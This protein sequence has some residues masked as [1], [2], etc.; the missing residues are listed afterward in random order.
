LG[1]IEWR[2]YEEERRKKEY[3]EEGILLYNGLESQLGGKEKPDSYEMWL[4]LKGLFLHVKTKSYEVLDRFPLYDTHDNVHGYEYAYVWRGEAIETVDPPESL[5]NRG[6][7]LE[8]TSRVTYAIS[9]ILSTLKKVDESQ[10]E[11]FLDVLSNLSW[12]ESYFYTKFLKRGIFPG[13]INWGK[14]IQ[15]VISKLYKHLSPKT[16]SGL[17]PEA[18]ARLL[19]ICAHT[20]LDL[21]GHLEELGKDAVEILVQGLRDRNPEIRKTAVAWLGDAGDKKALEPLIEVLK[22][23]NTSVSFAAVNALEKIG[24]ERAIEPLRCYFER[25]HSYQR[26]HVAD[27]I[28]AI[29]RTA[30]EPYVVMLEEAE[31]ERGYA[32][33]VLEKARKAITE[34]EKIGNERALDFLIHHFLN[35]EHSS[36]ATG[37]IARYLGRVGNEKAIEALIHLYKREKERGR[38]KWGDGK[39]VGEVLDQLGKRPK[40]LLEKLLRR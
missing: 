29:D 18:F 31:N 5:L 28:G 8:V 38:E 39:V 4:L 20:S 34:L 37:D 13:D 6:E 17:D 2:K 14:S 23:E 21:I 9:Q 27:A 22:D 30:I 35:E 1:R 16:I 24:D 10:Q 36:I 32:L 3:G 7:V 11:L 19:E 33:D 15:P 40:S 26:K 25:C 12:H